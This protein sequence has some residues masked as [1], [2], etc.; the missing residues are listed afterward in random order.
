MCLQDG[1]VDS[2]VGRNWSD[3]KDQAIHRENYKKLLQA[4][5]SVLFL[6]SALL[7]CRFSLVCIWVWREFL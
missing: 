7:P 3:G 6:N 4:K 1:D 2:G 5:T